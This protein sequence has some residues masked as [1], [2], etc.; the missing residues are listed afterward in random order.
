MAA[1][2]LAL[3]AANSPFRDAHAA[4]L[5]V[6]IE[7]RVAELKLA[8]PLLLW[9]NDGLM[10]IFFFLVGLEVKR[11]LVEGDLSSPAAAA[12]PLA[13]AVGG[14]AVPSAIYAAV[15]AGD[16]LAMR[17]WAIPAATD[18][19]FALG[20]L[21][22]LGARVPGSLKVLLSAIA[23]L[24]DLAAIG[25]I[26]VFYTEQ[27]SIPMLWL[28]AIGIAGLAA[29]NGFG[30]SRPAAYVLVGIFL[31]VCVLKSGVHATLAGVAT[32]LAIPLRSRDGR[33]PLEA[34]EHELSPWVAFGIVP[35]FALVN[36]GVS[37]D[38]VTLSTLIAPVPLGIA[39][40]L[41]AGKAV[42]VVLASWLVLGAGV[43][44]MPEG[45][46]F[47]HLVGTAFLCGVG[48]TMSLFIGAL[49]FPGDPER[50]E[51]VRLGVLVGSLA[52]A[53]VGIAVLRFGSR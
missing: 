19:A 7:I 39:L 46:R 52:S 41:F 47:I 31:W 33:R 11:A 37:L 26:A 21:L 40:G 13:A 32:A 29:L 43:A 15:N 44:R 51:A 4:L 9:V 48:F 50:M 16:A 10:A 27:L 34:V 30:V 18:I 53:L 17:G 20:V 6:P 12:L 2:A 35:V 36:A 49:A 24:D 3:V 14:I 23:V 22:L 1:A 8:K 38:G 28:S 25:I 5:A 45:A 42:G